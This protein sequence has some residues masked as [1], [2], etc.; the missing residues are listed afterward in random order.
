MHLTIKKTIKTRNPNSNSKP[1]SERHE[2]RTANKVIETLESYSAEDM[3]THILKKVSNVF[4]VTFD[5]FMKM[6]AIDENDLIGGYVLTS[7]E[8]YNIW[9]GVNDIDEEGIYAGNDGIEM[10]WTNWNNGMY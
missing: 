1:Y 10:D 7:T 5:K 2:R 3:K 8:D 9:I 6:S 4:K